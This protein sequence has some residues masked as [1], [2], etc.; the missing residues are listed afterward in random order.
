[1]EAELFGELILKDGCLRVQAREGDVSY[2]LV[3]P[4]DH[5]LSAENNEVQIRNETG[6][7]VAQVG[8]QV[9][10]TGGEIPAQGQKHYEETNPQ[11]PNDRCSGPYWIVGG[12]VHRVTIEDASR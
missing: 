10:I 12:E 3:W 9:R 1:M 11:L 6:Q 8:D 7:L 4:S 2:L 5:I